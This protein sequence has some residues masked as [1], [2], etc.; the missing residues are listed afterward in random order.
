MFR[1]IAIGLCIFVQVCVLILLVRLYV[2][3]IYL[4]KPH[5]QWAYKQI[6]EN[7]I[8]LKLNLFINVFSYKASSL[9]IML[10]IQT[11]SPTLSCILD[12]DEY[13]YN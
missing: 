11:I 6:S 5:S 1:H 4:W 3:C 9:D 12:V 13:V 2:L 8:I 10:K 7:S